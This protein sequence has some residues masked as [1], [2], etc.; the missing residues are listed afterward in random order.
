MHP[1]REPRVTMIEGRRT[2][3]I[4]R[5]PPL[6][7]R[8]DALLAGLRVYPLRITGWRSACSEQEHRLVLFAEGSYPCPD[9]IRRDLRLR[10]CRDCESV[11]VRDVSFDDP[12]DHDPRGRG[13]AFTVRRPL[14][15]INQVIGWYSGARRNQRQYR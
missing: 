5:T 7:R 11:E 13:V 10:M 6:P 2:L 9:G 12:A 3:V 15:R 8:L 14:R 1:I 4:E